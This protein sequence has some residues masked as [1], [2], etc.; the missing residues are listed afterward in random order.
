MRIT[1]GGWE[2]KARGRPKAPTSR[3]MM[4]RTALNWRVA[5][6]FEDVHAPSMRRGTLCFVCASKVKTLGH[7]AFPVISVNCHRTV[8]IGQIGGKSSATL[9]PVTAKAISPHRTQGAP[10]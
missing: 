4:T 7:P 3:E 9:A 8:K 5:H 10:L 1:G 6:L 2:C